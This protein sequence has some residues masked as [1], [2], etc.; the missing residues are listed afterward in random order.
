MVQALSETQYLPL[1]VETHTPGRVL[2]D[3]HHPA[4][5]ASFL[6]ALVITP[7]Q[8]RK[9]DARG[10]SLDEPWIAWEG[11][12][13]GRELDE[14]IPRPINRLWPHMDNMF[15]APGEYWLGGLENSSKPSAL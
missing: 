14:W 2:F 1:R 8:V 12:A 10:G 5:G 11:S 9:W 3:G 15:L 7:M 4:W 6:A 13:V